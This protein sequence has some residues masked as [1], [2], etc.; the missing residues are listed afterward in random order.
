MPITATVAVM[1][2]L[3]LASFPP[4]LG[5]LGKEILVDVSLQARGGA[6]ILTA[7]LA[8]A[9]AIFVACAGIVAVHPFFGTAPGTRGKEPQE[10]GPSL[11]LGPLLLASLGVLF[12]V[13]PALIDDSLVR[14]AARAFAGASSRSLTLWHGLNLPLA[15]SAVSFA[16]GI[17]LYLGRRQAHAAAARLQIR[18]GW[19]PQTWYGRL[20]AGMN[21][22]AERQ[23]KLLQSGYLRVYLMI[24]VATTLGLAGRPMLAVA[25]SADL[26]TISDLRFY[27]A[28]VVALIP[29]GA[30]TAITARTR[31]GAVAALGVV[32]YSVGLIFVLFGAPDLAMTQFMVE[33]LTVILLVLVFYHLRR[34]TTVSR[35]PAVVRDAVLASA[36]GGLV[37]LIVLV[38]SGLQLHPKISE[39]FFTHALSLA[40]G[41]NVVNVLLVDFRAFDTLGEITVLAVAGA[42]V[43]ALLKLK[44]GGESG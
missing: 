18:S 19:G 38:G 29:I 21:R 43:Y 13:W 2:G 12:G 11:W 36:F 10:A 6:V 26:A 14:P 30:V 28:I 27:E 31:L 4:T 3:S 37:T 7:A 17:A 41:R 35:W 39:Y 8:F 42:G 20:L 24:I 23:T 1:A 25:R 33:T 15:L 40:H 34:F 16:C 32:G 5:F 9:S 22:L 44:P